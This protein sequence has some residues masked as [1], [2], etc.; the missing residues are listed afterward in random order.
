MTP[1]LALGKP[2]LRTAVCLAAFRAV[3]GEAKITCRNWTVG[4][5]SMGWD[6]MGWGSMGWG[7]SCTVA[8]CVGPAVQLPD[9]LE[10]GK[11]FIACPH[12]CGACQ[13]SNSF[14]IAAV[15]TDSTCGAT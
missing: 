10:I 9:Q 11:L 3:R 7:S 1:H 13:S 2:G 4:W 14:R 12:C 8:P 6:S 5:D 15:S